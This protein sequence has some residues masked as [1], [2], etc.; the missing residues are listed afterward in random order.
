LREEGHRKV[1]CRYGFYGIDGNPLAHTIREQIRLLESAERV[2]KD[3]LERYC[4]NAPMEPAQV[5]M[6]SRFSRASST[7]GNEILLHERLKAKISVRNFVSRYIRLSRAGTGLCPLHDD[8]VDS[9]S[10]DDS[11]NFWY[12]FACE[13]GR[14][15]IDFWMF[16]W[17]C[18]FK[19][20]VK[21]LETMLL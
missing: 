12:C 21:Q 7:N 4:S 19:T 16:Y 18:D 17:D 8:H 15:I 20:T 1:G 13:I 2:P 11:C 9:F 14:S 10:V 5:S 3:K 6:Q